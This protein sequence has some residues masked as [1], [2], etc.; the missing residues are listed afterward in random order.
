MNNEVVFIGE[1]PQIKKL[2]KG[3]QKLATGKK[4]ILIAGHR[5]SGRATYGR[6]IHQSKGPDTTFRLI[7]P[8][9]SSEEEIYQILKDE[10]AETILIQDLEEFSF[11]QQKSF[12]DYIMEA[13]KKQSAQVIITIG[14]EKR[15]LRRQGRILDGMLSELD[16]F[17][18]V[19]IPPLTE[20]KDDIPYLMEHFARNACRTLGLRFK[21][22][23]TNT[24]EFLVRKEWKENVREL[25]SVIEK[26]VIAS[27]GSEIEIP[28][29]LLD[30]LNQVKGLVDTLADKKPISIDRSLHN[31]EKSIIERA[32]TMAGYNQLKAAKLL[33]ISESNLRYRLKKF[34]IAAVR[35]T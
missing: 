11:V 5:G 24:V 2:V 29:E 21:A 6:L 9:S 23:E 28:Q 27:Q 14:R 4:N 30:E 31:L 20:R 3:V 26:A 19:D 33:D 34:G 13:K 8:I 16:S 15:E 12:L 35:E 22:I 32:L 7:S 18:L 10:S 1:T 17:E 25:K